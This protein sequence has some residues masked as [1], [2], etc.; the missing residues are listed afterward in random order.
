MNSRLLQIRN[1]YN[2][3][4]E[5]FGNKLGLKKSSIS[6]YE[7]GKRDLTPQ[8]IKLI[9]REFPINAEWLVNGTGEML[10]VNDDD[11]LSENLAK[12]LMH[13]DDFVKKVFLNLSSLTQD[14]WDI[15]KQ[16]IAI[17]TKGTSIK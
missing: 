14:E 1:F 7:S 16:S 8:T 10:N 6:L 12:I 4:Q 17:L 5:E 2:L 11:L 9:C 13:E 15:I 3:T